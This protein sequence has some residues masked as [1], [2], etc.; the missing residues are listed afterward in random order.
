MRKTIDLRHRE[1][2]AVEAGIET[3]VENEVGIGEFPSVEDLDT[4]DHEISGVTSTQSAPALIDIHETI[5]RTEEG[6]G[7]DRG[8]QA[9]DLGLDQDRGTDSGRRR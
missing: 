9:V 1:H 3:T 4:K 2:D 6:V 8:G 5:D 7:A